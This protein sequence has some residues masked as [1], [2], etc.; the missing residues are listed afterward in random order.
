MLLRFG[1]APRALFGLALLLFLFA[2]SLG[3]VIRHRAFP[4]L[5]GD[6]RWWRVLLRPAGFSFPLMS[7]FVAK[8]T[9]LALI[10]SVL[11]IFIGVDIG[12][13]A[14][15]RVERFFFQRLARS[16]RVYKEKERLRL[17]SMTLFL[18]GCFISFLLFPYE[19]AFASVTFL[20]F[21]DLTAKVFGFA[22][23][24][25]RFFA[26]SLQGSLGYFSIS[27]FA[28]YGLSVGGLLPFWVGFLG[29]LAAGFTEALPLHVDD[30][31]SVPLLF[32]SGIAMLVTR[33][34]GG[35]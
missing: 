27:T 6:V 35:S 14:S 5:P 24:R 22:G 13:L 2:R 7:L 28:A 3:A 12:R 30:N 4:Y 18:L 11:L 8:Q 17:S 29:A 34:L 16:F 26:K 33:T 15:G 25:T 10:G 9:L 1:L 32:L 19:I 31:L 21:G 20:V 23:G